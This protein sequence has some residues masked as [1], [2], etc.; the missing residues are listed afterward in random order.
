MDSKQNVGTAT[1][2][3]LRK[4]TALVVGSSSVQSA[5]DVPVSSQPNKGRLLTELLKPL[6]LSLLKEQNYPL[7]TCQVCRLLN[8]AKHKN[9]IQFCRSN[10]ERKRGLSNFTRFGN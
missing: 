4:T 3:S 5:V 1:N 2:L 6:L 9:D 8:G 7:N 10:K